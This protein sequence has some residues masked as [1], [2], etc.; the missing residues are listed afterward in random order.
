MQTRRVVLGALTSAIALAEGV[1]PACGED[2]DG[3]SATLV[4]GEPSVLDYGD[5]LKVPCNK[6]AFFTLWEGNTFWITFGFGISP[7]VDA[8]KSQATKQA[9]GVMK[10][11]LLTLAFAPERLTRVAGG[12][13]CK[14]DPTAR[15]FVLGELELPTLPSRPLSDVFL[16]GGNI[17]ISPL[18]NFSGTIQ[19]GAAGPTRESS[20]TPTPGP[21]GNLRHAD[22]HAFSNCIVLKKDLSLDDVRKRAVVLRL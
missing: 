15:D 5:G 3:P 18:W 10:F 2:H 16:G 13:W 11:L 8:A 1:L 12:G 4:K 9:A 19:P 6:E 21:P 14:K 20:I 22:T 7:S 17:E